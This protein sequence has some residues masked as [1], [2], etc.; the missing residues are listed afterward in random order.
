MTVAYTVEFQVRPEQ[1]GRFRQLLDHILDVMREEQNFLSATLHVDPDDPNRFMLH[2]VW[3]DHTNV[4]E[5]QLHR[6]YRGKWHAALPGLLVSERVIHRWT[7]VRSD[8]AQ[9]RD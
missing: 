7:P 5:V 9:Y 4:V 2:E 8:R 6:E 3:R 1:H